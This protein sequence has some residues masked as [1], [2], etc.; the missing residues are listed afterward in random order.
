MRVLITGANGQLGKALQRTLSGHDLILRDLP[1]FDLTNAA[2]EDDIVRAKPNIILHA[3]A[4][5]N[6]DQAE[7]DPQQAHAVNAQGTQR[8]AQA[9][10]TLN[11][12]LIYVSTDYVFDGTKASPYHEQDRPRPANQYGQSKYFGEE[13]V[14]TLCPNGLVVRTAWLFGHEGKNFVK[15]IMQMAD[16]R[17]VLE[18]VADQRGCPTYADDLARALHQLAV[19]NL[20]GICHV[21]NTGD[22][23]WYEFAQAIVSRTEGKA[24]VRPITTAQ[25]GRPAKRPTYSVLSSDRFASHYGALPD[26]QD[27]LSRFMKRVS[28]PLS[29]A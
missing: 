22:C 8:V 23:S 29:P 12:R 2:C 18:V 19:S 14:L 28:Q 15:T 13:A 6:V 9:A 3:G 11:A 16:E 5:T 17:P 27:A 20:H 1:E 24:V 7:R 21:T 10:K 26:W 25:A 4:Y